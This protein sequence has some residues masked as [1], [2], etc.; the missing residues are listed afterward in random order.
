MA[1]V[2]RIAF[3]CRAV[4]NRIRQAGRRSLLPLADFDRQLF[5]VG[6][7]KAGSTSLFAYL[8]E[9]P[10]ICASDNKETEFFSRDERFARGRDYYRS[11]FAKRS[12]CQYSMDATPEY[13]Y[14][15]RCAERIH[16]YYP[17]TARIVMVLR[18]PVSRAFSAFNMYQQLVKQPWFEDYVKTHSPA[19]R[20]FFQP[21]IDG[22][23]PVAIDRFIQREIEIIASGASV[24][25]P[26]LIRRGLYGAQ[27][28][29][30]VN[31]FGRDRVLI[32]FSNELR[33]EPA[34]AVHKVLDF[35]GLSPLDDQSFPMMHVRPYTVD[36]SAKLVIEQYAGDMFTEDKRLLTERYGLS[37]PW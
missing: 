7:Q 24:E 17:D 30:F 29:H 25:E 2:E 18:E 27:I 8:A 6:A 23:M 9:H 37:V 34:V 20:D 12:G 28:E 3:N 11:L 1:L 10:G 35:A 32:L 31:L 14:Y 4:I 15:P 16:S 36:A 22:S 33:Q 5:V 21:F 26:G 13:M 19:M